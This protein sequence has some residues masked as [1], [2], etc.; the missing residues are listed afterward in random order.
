MY[1][2]WVDQRAAQKF[3]GN[4]PPSIVGA[5]FFPVDVRNSK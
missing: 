4:W 2:M 1:G 3:A 5:D